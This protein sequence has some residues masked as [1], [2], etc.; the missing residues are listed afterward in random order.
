MNELPILS[1]RKFISYT[2]DQLWSI[3]KG[4]FSLRF[5]NGEI[6][7][8]TGKETLY[9]RILWLPLV[10][11]PD[12]PILPTHHLTVVAKGGLP[13]SSTHRKILSN[14]AKSIRDAY[15]LNTP[16]SMKIMRKL[17]F[18]AMNDLYNEST[19]R[20]SEY[21]TSIDIED[22][23]EVM[24]NKEIYN[25]YK[26]LKEISKHTRVTQRNIDNH[27]RVILNILKKEK[28]LDHNALAFTARVGLANNNQILQM[29][30]PRGFLT[31]VDSIIFQT[32]ILRGYIEG[33][34]TLYESGIESRSAAKSLY[35]SEDPLKDSEYFA[36]RLQ[37]LTMVVKNV[38]YG[39]CG[40][41]SY[42]P[43]TVKGKRYNEK[44][45]IIYKGDLPMLV[46][47][48]Y[49]DEDGILKT[50]KI[51]D[52][53]LIGKI[54]RM[55]TTVGGC[56]HPDPHGVC[57]TCFG[58]MYYNLPEKANL[59]HACSSTA[60]RDITQLT[61]SVKHY[62]GSSDIEPLMLGGLNSQFFIVGNDFNS[63]YLR[64]DMQKLKLKMI[65]PISNAESLMELTSIS[66]I[67]NI[68]I[69]R[70]TEINEIA[71]QFEDKEGL[72]TINLNVAYSGRKG[73]LSR[74]FLKYIFNGRIETDGGKNF[75]FNLDEW[76]CSK[77]I[78]VL[79]YKHY[80]MADHGKEVAQV[81]EK[82]IKEIAEKGQRVTPQETLETLFDLM[83]SRLEM[84][85]SLLEI[86]V[87]SNMV[88]SLANNDYRLPKSNTTGE[89]NAAPRTIRNRSLGGM[90]AYEGQHGA[91]IDPYSFFKH[92]R[93]DH[94]M[95]VFVTP[96]EVIKYKK[97]TKLEE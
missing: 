67:E 96:H 32:P 86:I 50:I 33:L 63:Y 71:M 27:Y 70:V 56:K 36:R 18:K 13:T 88:V 46:G 44:G 2:I 3:C 92:H 14:I 61:L 24:E 77:P 73:I 8:T 37:I 69:N 57:S 20:I 25:S 79:P 11:Y 64:E 23:I 59:G 75:I 74:D 40:S 54:I 85:I 55:R 93:I 81:I 21:V 51:S 62:D 87:Y 34:K 97:I 89:M 47:K 41:T 29:V 43:W 22:F 58:D 80:N 48:K 42:M 17:I 66:D 45:E 49:M 35:F 1:A 72:S 84:N 30:G 10:H 19:S 76:D 7:Q 95:D 83:N 53:H 78:I 26:E 39:D 91:I 68:S 16:Q 94:A 90:Y 4:R 52:E 6:I 82:T 28:T 31:D 9:S 60:T 38:H 15:N 5:D 65:I 12:T